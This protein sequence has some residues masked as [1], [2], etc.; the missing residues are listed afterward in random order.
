MIHHNLEYLGLFSFSSDYELVARNSHTECFESLTFLL[1]KFL[2]ESIESTGNYIIYLTWKKLSYF[3]NDFYFDILSFHNLFL[4]TLGNIW[5][6]PRQG[7]ASQG[8]LW[9]FFSLPY[10][11]H[12]FFFPEQW[13][14]LSYIIFRMGKWKTDTFVKK[15]MTFLM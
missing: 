9:H 15:Q 11:P 13:S 7:D 14:L 6:C 4:C 2:V 12:C 1:R 8:I 10:S 5:Y 3:P